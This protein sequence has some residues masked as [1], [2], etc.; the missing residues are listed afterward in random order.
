MPTATNPAPAS[1][2][3]DRHVDGAVIQTIARWIKT[4]VR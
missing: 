4:Q 2:N 1:L 3:H